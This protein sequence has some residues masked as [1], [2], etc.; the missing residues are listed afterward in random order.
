VRRN[1][2]NRLSLTIELNKVSREH[3]DAVRKLQ[4]DIAKTHRVREASK[5]GLTTSIE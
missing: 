4:Y 3:E 1:C 5:S 2:T